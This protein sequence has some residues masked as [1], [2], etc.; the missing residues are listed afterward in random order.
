MPTHTRRPEPPDEGDELRD[1][2]IEDLK[3]Q[4]VAADARA[5]RAEQRLARMSWLLAIVSAIAALAG[6]LGGPAA[7]EALQVFPGLLGGAS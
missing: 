4:L 5:S 2:Q 7:L 6:V 1:R 3:A